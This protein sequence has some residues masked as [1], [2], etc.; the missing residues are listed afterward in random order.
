MLLKSS[1]WGWLIVTKDYAIEMEMI[2]AVPIGVPAAY[3]FDASIRTT[4]LES[5]QKAKEFADNAKESADNAKSSADSAKTSADNAKASADIAEE[6]KEET[7]VIVEEAKTEI[8]NKVSEAKKEIDIKV[9]DAKSD[10]NRK[11]DE[12][13]S[14]VNDEKRD[15]Y[16]KVEDAKSEIDNKVSEAKQEV[17]EYVDAGCNRV[18][19][20]AEEAETFFESKAEEV[21]DYA[22]DASESALSAA[23]SA[24]S[25]AA[26]KAE[27][28]DSTKT[29]NYPD[30]VCYTDGFSYRCLGENVIGDPPDI[31]DSWARLVPMWKNFWRTDPIK[32]DE[33][34]NVSAGAID[35]ERLN[36]YGVRMTVDE[37]GNII[38][39]PIVFYSDKFKYN[40]DGSIS[41][42]V[43]GSLAS[44][45]DTFGTL[46]EDEGERIFDELV[47]G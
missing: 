44:D 6:I 27:A 39:A 22:D 23:D 40:S 11:V 18:D 5:A 3:D 45:E 19:K 8:N 47:G 12:T 26:Y 41:P 34:G 37:D 16:N 36:H 29:Y 28:W 14:F 4:A 13:I 17:D 21:K 2:Q 24:V 30:V 20:K 25:A 31:S 38:P 46:T 7:K 43:R 1:Y 9:A 15:I 10:I 32:Y 35:Y 33:D 42:R